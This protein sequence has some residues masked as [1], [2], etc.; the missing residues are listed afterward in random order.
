MLIIERDFIRRLKK[1]KRK[2]YLLN[3]TYSST[4]RY[5]KYH[6]TAN[7]IY[8]GLI[9]TIPL[10][11]YQFDKELRL[12]VSRSFMLTLLELILTHIK[13]KDLKF[14]LLIDESKFNEK[15]EINYQFDQDCSLANL[16]QSIVKSYSY[17]NNPIQT[18]IS[19]LPNQVPL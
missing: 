12:K 19:N 18:L 15:Y 17:I 16:I 8:S 11:Y 10:K 13:A 9:L 7:D 14:S 4:L 3:L 5:P 6:F 2:T 1:G